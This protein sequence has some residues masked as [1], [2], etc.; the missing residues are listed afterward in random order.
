MVNKRPISI[1]SMFLSPNLTYRIVCPGVFQRNGNELSNQT[2]IIDIP[3]DCLTQDTAITTSTPETPT[4]ITT[5]TTGTATTKSSLK[6]KEKKKRVSDK[7]TKQSNA[8]DEEVELNKEDDEYQDKGSNNNEDEGAQGKDYQD[9]AMETF[10]EPVYLDDGDIITTNQAL[11]PNKN[12][13]PDRLDSDNPLLV[14]MMS[15]P[16]YEFT[17]E[18]MAKGEEEEEIICAETFAKEEKK[19][20]INSNKKR[21]E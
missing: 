3:S 15:K 13:S 8:I 19:K 11:A 10:P 9:T 7:K 12:N 5:S 20:S 14:P 21:G 1:W 17:E 16:L 4:P 18:E 2:M 6:K